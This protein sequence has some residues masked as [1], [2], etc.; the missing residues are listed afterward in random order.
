MVWRHPRALPNGQLD[1]YVVHWPR[2]EFVKVG[3]TKNQRWRTFQ[4]RGGQALLVLRLPSNKALMIERHV[5]ETL[6]RRLE[7]PFWLEREAER[8]LGSGGGGYTEC[9]QD[10]GSEVMPVVLEAASRIAW[11]YKRVTV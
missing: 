6:S 8:Y 9:Y 2:R 10:D 4:S 5:H 3:M 7:C 1:L 11:P